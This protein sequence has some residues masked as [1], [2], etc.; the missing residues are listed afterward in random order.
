VTYSA[1]VLF[2]IDGTLIRRAGPHHRRALVEAVR[3]AT[4]LETTT[5]S[6]PVHGMLDPDILTAMMRNA[7]ASSSLIR[8]QMPAIVSYAQSYYA[9][10]CINLE[11]KVCPGVRHALRRLKNRGALIAL[12]TGNITRIGWKKMEL[13]GLK[14]YFRFGMFGEMAPSRAGLARMA[15]EQ[16]RENRWIAPGARISLIGDAPS[17]I[18]A[19]RENRIQSIAVSTGITPPEDLAALKPDYLLSTL[20]ELK[21]EMVT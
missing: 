3:H 18:L 11:R 10:N 17:D 4:G 19:A 12:V 21:P 20:R 2:D 8:R 6:I 14:P 7:G 13:C 15:I 1:L 5:D 9:R 16:A